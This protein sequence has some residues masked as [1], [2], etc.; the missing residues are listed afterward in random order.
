MRIYNKKGFAA[1]VFL[2]VLG[3]GGMIVTLLHPEGVWEQVREL[4][5]GLFLLICGSSSLLRAVSREKSV[6]DKIE[7]LDER[8]H[9]VRLKS[10][11]ATLKI[12]LGLMAFLAVAGLAGYLITSN[13]GWGFIFVTCGVLLGIYNIVRCV[14]EIY[15]EYRL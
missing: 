7:A 1:G 12:L 2:T 15:Y 6:E 3:G 10:Q 13:I 11:S 5:T 14:T 8:S 9:A 4:A